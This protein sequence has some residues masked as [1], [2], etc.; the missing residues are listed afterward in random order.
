MP[1][2]EIFADDVSVW[3]AHKPPTQAI[4]DECAIHA[5]KKGWNGTVLELRCDGQFRK[6]LDPSP[7]APQ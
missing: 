3:M 5:T 6:D 7:E 4:V 2:Y 1:R